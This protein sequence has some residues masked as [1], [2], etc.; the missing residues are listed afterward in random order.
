VT[1]DGLGSLSGFNPAEFVPLGGVAL[2][3]LRRQTA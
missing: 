3:R 2:L 1:V